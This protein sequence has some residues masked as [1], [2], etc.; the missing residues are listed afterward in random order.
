MENLNLSVQYSNCKGNATLIK[1]NIVS[2]WYYNSLKYEFNLNNT[3]ELS[4]YL[5]VLTKTSQLLLMVK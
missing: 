1:R 5:T 2:F 4:S 3:Y